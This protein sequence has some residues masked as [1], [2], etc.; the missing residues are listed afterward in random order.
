M[1]QYSILIQ[2]WS[3]LLFHIQF[4]Q[5]VCTCALTNFIEKLYYSH[6]RI[7][8]H[9]FIVRVRCA[10]ATDA[11]ANSVEFVRLLSTTELSRIHPAFTTSNR[12]WVSLYVSSVVASCGL[13]HTHTNTRANGSHRNWTYLL[14]D[15][16]FIAHIPAN[17]PI[18]I[19]ILRSNTSNTFMRKRY[20]IS[21][22]RML[23]TEYILGICEGSRSPCERCERI[24]TRR[25]NKLYQWCCCLWS[26]LCIVQL[27]WPGCWGVRTFEHS[28]N[29]QLPEH[30]ILYRKKRNHSFLTVIS[31][32]MIKYNY[33]FEREKWETYV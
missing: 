14:F 9:L 8:I 16:F 10:R 4:V 11:E 30:A 7:H 32:R 21:A 33:I 17:I 5:R 15:N 2:W 28:Q 24:S 19:Y 18:R 13:V 12:D 31:G 6:D 20:L 26:T 29:T 23:R 1:L 25:N 27:S 3:L 22:H